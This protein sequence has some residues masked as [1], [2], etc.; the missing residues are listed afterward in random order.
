M[1]THPPADRGIFHPFGLAGLFEVSDEG[2]QTRADESG[3]RIG[4]CARFPAAPPRAG[5]ERVEL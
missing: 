1:S 3:M 4:V 2:I 5:P